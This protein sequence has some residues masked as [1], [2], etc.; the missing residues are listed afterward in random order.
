VNEH[1]AGDSGEP[2]ATDATPSAHGERQASAVGAAPE[3]VVPE[4]IIIEA[5]AK[6]NLYLEILGRRADGYHEI[7]TLMQTVSLADRLTLRS[8]S[9]ESLRLTLKGNAE[10]VPDGDANLVLKAVKALSERIRPSGGDGTIR[11][12]DIELEKRIPPGSGLGGGSSDAA[13]TLVGL[14]RLWNIDASDEL[15]VEVAADLG[16]D[17][18]FFIRGGAARCTGRGEI[19]EHLQAKGTMYAVLVFDKPLGTKCV[20][21]KLAD[22]QLTGTHSSGNV[23]VSSQGSVRLG[24]MVEMP[25]INALEPAAFLARPGL[26]EVKQLLLGA[27]ASQACLSGSGSCVYGVAESERGAEALASEVAAS[28]RRCAVIRSVGPRC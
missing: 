2:G 20:Y 25:L 14:R 28:G 7:D 16:S 22:S 6:I 8:R 1:L 3:Q 19:V 15:L 13:A 11:G 5:P 23:L 17:V 9:D 4:Q 12:A 26:R 27:G 21:E 24:G 10:G 18:P